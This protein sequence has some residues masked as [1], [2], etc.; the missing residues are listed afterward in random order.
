MREIEKSAKELRKLV[1]VAAFFF[2]AI[3]LSL[4]L[5]FDV[6]PWL[7]FLIAAVLVL[8]YVYYKGNELDRKLKEYEISTAETERIHNKL[9]ASPTTQTIDWKVFIIATLLMLAVLP[10][11]FYFGVTNETQL[12]IIFFIAILA[13]IALFIWRGYTKTI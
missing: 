3:S 2:L 1:Y 7:A 13:G 11:V 8:P 6:N 4:A 12:S 10:V 5:F 9:K